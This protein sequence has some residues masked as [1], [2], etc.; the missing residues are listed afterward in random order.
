MGVANVTPTVSAGVLTT[1]CTITA[2]LLPLYGND[3]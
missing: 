1:Q 3:D 2:H